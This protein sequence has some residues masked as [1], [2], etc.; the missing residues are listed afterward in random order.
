MN[1]SPEFYQT[2]PS[3]T[4]RFFT[5]E[6]NPQSLLKVP[7]EGFS[8]MLLHDIQTREL[9]AP[10]DDKDALIATVLSKHLLFTHSQLLNNLPGLGPL[11]SPVPCFE[12]K[13]YDMDLEE[14][15]KK[16][17]GLLGKLSAEM[18][19]SLMRCIFRKVLEAVQYVFSKGVCHRNLSLQHFLV[20]LKCKRIILTDFSHSCEIGGTGQVLASE[21]I[22]NS[23]YRAPELYTK[24]ERYNCVKAETF[25]L[26][27][28][29][30]NLIFNSSPFQSADPKNIH[31]RNL[32][33]GSRFKNIEK[34]PLAS[35]FSLM[36]RMLDTNPEERIKFEE[37]LTHPW[38]VES[39]DDDQE[40]HTSFIFKDEVNEG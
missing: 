33:R 20:D 16:R 8:A 9:I 25:S 34:G 15:L 19:C 35:V 11:T 7:K 3:E 36:K 12:M 22:G 23:Y 18:H 40:H 24:V 38:I 21:Y 28:I 13:K 31:F 10:P 29:L 2:L 14:F 27:V 4:N 32:F 5:K 30:Y 37:V 6:A 26:G 39:G 1:T 17:R